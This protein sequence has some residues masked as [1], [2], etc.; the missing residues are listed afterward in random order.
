MVILTDC[1]TDSQTQHIFSLKAYVTMI[2]KYF[3]LCA[4]IKVKITCVIPMVQ[5]L[6]ILFL[7]QV[8]EDM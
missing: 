4:S 3:A 7:V 2:E 6:F 1:P 5:K 8:S